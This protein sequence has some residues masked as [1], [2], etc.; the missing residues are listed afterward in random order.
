MLIKAFI[1][2]ASRG[3]PG[4]SGLGV[5]I[6]DNNGNVIREIYQYL[7]KATNNQAE[8]SALIRLLRE[9]ISHEDNFKDVRF[10]TIHSDSELL[11]R[12]MRGEYKVKS[13]NII[14]YH[15]EARKILKKLP[16]TVNFIHIPR[17]EN[18]AADRLANFAIDSQI[19]AKGN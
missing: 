8:Y 18:K 5:L 7:G 6:T 9:M 16:Y 17:E 14:E 1:D 12:Q 3:N 4:Q 13:R 10:L 11:V 15:L 19:S 2:G